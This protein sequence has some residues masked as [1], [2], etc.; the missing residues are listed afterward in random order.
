MKLDFPLTSYGEQVT[1]NTSAN[2]KKKKREREREKRER[3]SGAIA[4]R[5]DRRQKTE[6]ERERERERRKS[7]EER[8]GKET[9][10]TNDVMPSHAS[11]LADRH[12]FLSG[13]EIHAVFYLDRKIP[14]EVFEDMVKAWICRNGSERKPTAMELWR[15]LATDV[16]KPGMP[17]EVHESLFDLNYLDWDAT[18]LGPPPVWIPSV[19]AA[20]KARALKVVLDLQKNARETFSGAGGRKLAE[21]WPNVSLQ[22]LEVA[23]AE[24]QVFSTRNQE[25]FWGAVCKEL[26]VRFRQRPNRM[27]LSCEG[28]RA[29]QEQWFPGG[30]MNITDSCFSNSSVGAMSD[31]VALVWAK[32]GQNDTLVCGNDGNGSP[33]LNTWTY[34]DLLERSSRIANCLKC[35]GVGHGSR[36]GIC[37]PMTA[38][39]V[40]I[41]LAVVMAGGAI[42]GIA[43]SFS[44][45]EICTR[46]RVAGADA[47]VTQDALFR[48]SKLIPLYDRIAGA[49]NDYQQ[50]TGKAIQVFCLPS[51]LPSGFTPE[52][53]SES[54]AGGGRGESSSYKLRCKIR[55]VD[56]PYTR[57]LSL[58]SST[59]FEAHACHPQDVTNILFSSGTTG[60][61][62]AIPWDHV[63]P[64]KCASDAMLHH[65]VNSEDVVCWPTNLGWMMG[66]WLLYA[67]L[68]NG[69]AVAI[70]EG[71][72]LGKAFCQFVEMAGVTM[73]G[74][75]PS[76]V[77]AW[78]AKGSTDGRDWTSIRRFSSSGEASN[79]KD[80]HWLSARV[81][82]YAPVIEYIGGTELAGGY[83]SGSL[84]QAQAPSHFSVHAFGTD[85]RLLDSSMMEMEGQAIEEAIVK[86]GACE[87]EV[88]IVPPMFGS[89][90]RL[91]NRDHDDVYFRD[92]PSTSEGTRM[93]KHGDMLAFHPCGYVKAGGRTDDTMNLGGIKTSSLEIENVCNA[94]IG[95]AGLP[96]KE[97]AAVAVPPVGGGPD[98]LWVCAAVKGGSV[99]ELRKSGVVSKWR[100]HFQKAVSKNLNPLFKVHRVML[101]KDLPRT[102]SNKI[103][104]K[105]LKAQCLAQSNEA[106][107][108]KL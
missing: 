20:R 50:E 77:K 60:E 75:V 28:S 57:L 48:G 67:G 46:L 7:E 16:L 65:D 84:V 36:V 106:V 104:R 17:F 105:A 78:K 91:L 9:P 4:W 83:M 82:G 6:R 8:K 34:A 88:A 3:E 81:K 30:L 73:L 63:A 74:T 87:G 53:E 98:L 32:E 25:V 101:V 29:G 99:E 27:Y 24:L 45:H 80:Y 85:L 51:D 33:Q 93:R 96:V 54:G 18:K 86:T 89:S 49:A 41:Y 31:Q 95:S 59:E 97:V 108:S 38:E 66:P 12:S 11:V 21:N 1:E 102:A 43:D 55:P 103:M 23:Y 64:L 19:E 26:G 13:L 15:V 37:M 100:A 79:P 39:S 44:R 52:S 61:P 58:S 40:A 5:D 94:S 22:Q 76:I 70:F 10:T 42:I 71:S 56:L 72:P 107:K 2:R 35:V 62:K 47:V 14:A 92:M 68:V 69:A 90:Y